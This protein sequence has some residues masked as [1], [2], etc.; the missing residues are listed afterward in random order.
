MATDGDRGC[1]DQDLG[2]GGVTVDALL[3]SLTLAQR[4]RLE[5]CC[6]SGIENPDSDIGVYILRP[7]DVREFSAFFDPLI[8]T[9]HHAPPAEQ[10]VSDWGP[11]ETASDHV[12]DLSTLGLPPVSMRIRVARNLIGF[13]LPGMMDRDER[14]QLELSMLQALR[15]FIAHPDYGGR[16]YSLTPE[17]GPDHPNPN[18]ITRREYQALVDAHIMFKDMDADPYLKSAGLSADWPYGRACYVSR[19]QDVIVWIGEE[20]H[21][22]II[23][24]ETGT[25]LN[26]VYQRLRNVVE[27]I[28]AMPGIAFAHDETF[29]YITSCPSNL[30][31]GMRASVHLRMPRLTGSGADLKA[32]CTLAGLSVCG[33]AGDHAPIGADGTLDLSPTRRLCVPERDIIKNLFQGIRQLAISQDCHN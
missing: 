1:Q 28:E 9:Y 16:I 26:D 32:A 19:D 6:R 27:M 13:R 7:E 10:H 20:D 14:L 3:P 12:L 8:R 17:F 31:T 23:C 24:M 22:R 33:L 29:G 18:R 25:R 11:R 2:F 15:P 21:L 30:G 5:Q 4:E